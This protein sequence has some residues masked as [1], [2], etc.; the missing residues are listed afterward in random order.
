MNMEIHAV[1]SCD[2]QDSHFF[3][4]CM[5]V[6]H[7]SQISEVSQHSLMQLNKTVIITANQK[8]FCT[9]TSCK[10]PEWHVAVVHTSS[11]L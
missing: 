1:I 7:V 5:T 3:A 2:Y 9:F 11:T 6:A 8:G 10:V 4:A